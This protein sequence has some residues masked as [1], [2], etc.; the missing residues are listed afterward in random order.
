M[1]TLLFCALLG[2]V[3]YLSYDKWFASSPPLDQPPVEPAG[4]PVVEAAPLQVGL[5]VKTR[6]RKLLEE[7]KLRNAGTEKRQL[8]T[9]FKVDMA[10]LLSEIKLMGPHTEA[11]I[12]KLMLRV[13]PELGVARDEV[14]TVADEILKQA[15]RDGA[16]GGH[17]RSH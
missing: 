11:G 8:G 2:A 14:G 12:R 7:W 1:K 13:L 16:K 15:R 17:A 5:A 6:I 10:V 3:G 4:A 9:A